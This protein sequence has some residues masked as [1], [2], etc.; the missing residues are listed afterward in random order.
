MKYLRVSYQEKIWHTD[1]SPQCRVC[2]Y[3]GG[4]NTA[5]AGKTSQVALLS[6][7]LSCP[8]M[9]PAAFDSA[10]CSPLLF[11]FSTGGFG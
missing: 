10:C 8:E 1:I 5:D 2:E 3:L 6:G 4:R 9:F 7:C 11:Q